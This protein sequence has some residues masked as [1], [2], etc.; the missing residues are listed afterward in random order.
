M[1][2]QKKTLIVAIIIFIAVL[3]TA[4]GFF[5]LRKQ[6]FISPLPQESQIKIIFTSPPPTNTPLPTQSITNT[7]V[8]KPTVNPT[9]KTTASPTTKPTA[10]PTISVTPTPT[11]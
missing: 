2:E 1:D 10:T 5:V 9:P 6:T 3:S 11:P 7:P 4:V 8:K